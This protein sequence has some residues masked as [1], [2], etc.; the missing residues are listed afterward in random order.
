[1]QIPV[2]LSPQLVPKPLWGISGHRK[3]HR[4]SWRRIRQDALETAGYRCEICGASPPLGGSLTCHEVWRYDDRCATATLVRFEIHCADC[5]TVTHLG[6]AM[7][8]GEGNFAFEQLCKVNGITRPEARQVYTRAV[9]IW[10]D[11]NTKDWRVVVDETLLQRYPCLAVL[12]SGSH[13]LDRG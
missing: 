10:K 3:L 9:T 13:L 11:R 12:D 7:K 5:D 4:D 6:R 2:K 8:H 1:M